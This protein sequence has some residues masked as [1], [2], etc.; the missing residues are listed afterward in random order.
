MI[1]P[2]PRRLAYG[3]TGAGRIRPGKTLIVVVDPVRVRG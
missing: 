3:S 1:L 2:R